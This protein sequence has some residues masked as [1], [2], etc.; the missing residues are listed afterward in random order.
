MRV[1]SAGP[2]GFGVCE[3]LET[4]AK[5]FQ[6]GGSEDRLPGGMARRDSKGRFGV[7]KRN[8]PTTA[9]SRVGQTVLRTSVMCGVSPYYSSLSLMCAAKGMQR[10]SGVK[11]G[12]V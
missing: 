7:A 3:A 8:G 6:L 11:R 10:T 2:K 1:G 9:D 5:D 12:A 4:H